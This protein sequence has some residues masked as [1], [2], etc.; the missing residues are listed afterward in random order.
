MELNELLKQIDE[1]LK[2]DVRTYS[3][4]FKALYYEAFH[5]NWSGCS[6]NQNPMKQ[7]LKQFYLNNIN[8]IT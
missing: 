4:K 2:L 5:K 3:T 8:N 6:C 1:A 7:A